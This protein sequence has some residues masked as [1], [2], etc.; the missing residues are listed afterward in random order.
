MTKVKSEQ[1]MGSSFALWKFYQDEK[2]DVNIRRLVAR[3]PSQVLISSLT[4]LEFIGVLMKYYRQGFIKRRHV[5]AIAQ[6]LRRDSAVGR[7]NR[8]FQVIQIPDGSFREAQGI[9][10]QDGSHYDLQANDALHL[11]I[12]VKLG[13]ADSVVLV[14]SDGALQNTA[15][16]RGVDWYD[17]EDSGWSNRN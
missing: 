10:L 17:P 3:S 11:A 8:P 12:V 4:M 2:G 15:Q 7:T 6:R 14:T 1:L 13:V 9:L 16:R 5:R